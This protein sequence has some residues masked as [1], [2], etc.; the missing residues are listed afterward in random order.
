[1]AFS[2]DCFVTGYEVR[3]VE[4]SVSKK[5]NKFQVIKLEDKGG[6]SVEVCNTSDDLMADVDL[7]KRG[8]M[9]NLHIRAVGGRQRQYLQLLAAPVVTG[10]AYDAPT[11]Y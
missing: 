9:V 3:A 10:S 5:G 8:D 2:L 11:E 6:Y 1:M 4:T 7:L